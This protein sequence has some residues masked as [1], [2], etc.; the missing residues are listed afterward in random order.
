MYEM[1]VEVYKVIVGV[2]MVGVLVHGR[3]GCEQSGCVRCRKVYEGGLFTR[4]SGY[5]YQ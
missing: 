5:G 2:Y 3:C 4:C 1:T